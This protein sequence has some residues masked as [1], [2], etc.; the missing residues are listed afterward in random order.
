MRARVSC[1]LR[2]AVNVDHRIV[3]WVE[4][5]I[6][7]QERHL[8]ERVG[9]EVAFAG[10]EQN[11]RCPQFLVRYFY[12]HSLYETCQIDSNQNQIVK[13]NVQLGEVIIAALD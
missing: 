8:L 12:A 13:Q 11:P 5:D 6:L 2:E 10:E 3:E 4:A 9:R 1:V 7:Q